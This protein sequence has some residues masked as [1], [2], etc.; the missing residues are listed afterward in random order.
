[1]SVAAPI[2]YL[3]VG[4]G[5]SSD[6]LDLRDENRYGFGRPNFA[7]RGQI[8]VP[9]HF[10]GQTSN[11]MAQNYQRLA[12]KLEQAAK[13]W[14]ERDTSKRVTF[15]WQPR[16]TTP[17]Y[18]DVIGGELT[19]VRI[20][21]LSKS[22][23][24]TMLLNVLPYPR[25][26]TVTDAVTG[27]LTNGSAQ[28]L[29]P[30]VL[31]DY[32]AL[33]KLS[34]TDTS[35]SGVINR[36]RLALRSERGIS[37][38]EDF[39]P[40]VDAVALS[41]GAATADATAF[42]GTYIHDTTADTSWSNLARLVMP[43]GS[44][45]RGRRDLWAR[46]WD[47]A[48]AMAQPTL[49][50]ATVTAPSAVTTT[51]QNYARITPGASGNGRGVSAITD[52]VTANWSGTTTAG[53]LLLAI[54]Y[55]Q[56]VSGTPVAPTGG[57]TWKLLTTITLIS[58]AGNEM[59]LYVYYQR[60]AT[61]QSGTVTWGWGGADP[62]ALNPMSLRL[63][64]L[65]DADLIFD[66]SSATDTANTSE[67]VGIQPDDTSFTNEMILS[68]FTVPG[69]NT[70][71][72]TDFWYGG[73]E[74]LF[75]GNSFVGGYTIIDNAGTTPSI[76]KVRLDATYNAS[77]NLNL[78]IKPV[79]T[80][81][82]LV[83]YQDPTPGEVLAGAYAFRVQA[84]DALGVLS[85]ASASINATPTLDRSAITLSWTA[86]VGSIAYYKITYSF[87]G[88]C[89][90]LYT[91]DASTTYTFTTT[92]GHPETTGLPATTGAVGSPARLKVRLGTTGSLSTA[93]SDA[94]EVGLTGAGAWRM[95]KIAGAKDL[96]PV[97]Q[98]LNGSQPEW[99][100]ELQARSV[101]G[102]D[103]VVRVDA[104]WLAP[105]D[106]WQATLEYPTLDLATKRRWVVE[107]DLTG[108]SMT[109][110]LENT[111]TGAESGRVVSAG[112]FLL[113]PGDNIIALLLEQA[114]ELASL[115]ASCTVVLSYTPRYDWIDGLLE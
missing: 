42:G 27:T 111:G 86:P 105:H 35:T 13:A 56:V 33:V 66:L 83:E 48:T 24:C 16:T 45:N 3:G 21:P 113:E 25:G 97:G 67:P 7:T 65:K 51:T 39:D 2:T 93:L 104:L 49:G 79:R 17:V 29:R 18:F 38:L 108:R 103:V 99:A 109:G 22:A 32:P 82:S 12:R 52:Q 10:R 55:L 59:Y 110:W 76:P 53:S 70:T 50:S 68:L 96:P 98:H 54:G 6:F 107:S 94:N 44:L 80:E 28:F 30:N 11:N 78:H 95:V 4:D 19:P 34:L 89:Y 90:Y 62:S 1:M 71:D 115:S 101:N 57:G 58:E 14:W 100:I 36:I 81:S 85:D 31:G 77:L 15:T 75:G 9:V 41:P 40:W 63:Q 69:A 87:A 112:S 43:S 60:N 92:E 64:E 37:A 23:E 91:I 74:P 114:D 46:I 72:P 8:T 73:Y 20:N 5:P 61:A 47:T 26:E 106:E 88:R 102:L 84:A